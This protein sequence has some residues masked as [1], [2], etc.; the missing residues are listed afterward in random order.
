MK[1]LGKNSGLKFERI[2]EMKYMNMPTDAVVANLECALANRKRALRRGRQ[3]KLL[4]Y[5]QYVCHCLGKGYSY[6]DT[7]DL[8]FGAYGLRVH[9][10]TLMRFAVKHPPL[11]RASNASSVSQM[12]NEANGMEGK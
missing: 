9:K 1:M 12:T 11:Q 6:Q 5:M 4:P 8:L 7:C 2:A 3:S 10:T